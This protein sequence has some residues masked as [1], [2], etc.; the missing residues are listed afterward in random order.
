MK[1]TGLGRPAAGGAGGLWPPWAVRLRRRARLEV[2]PAGRP[3]ERPGA[4]QRAGAGAEWRRGRGGG[5]PGATSPPV[6]RSERPQDS[7]GAPLRGEA[8][9][10]RGPR[11]R[12]ARAA[13]S[14]R[15]AV[16]S[17]LGKEEKDYRRRR[18]W[19]AR[20]PPPPSSDGTGGTA[21]L[22][23]GFFPPELAGGSRRGRGGGRPHRLSRRDPRRRAAARQ[24]SSRR[25][26]SLPARVGPRA[27]RCWRR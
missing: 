9:G 4:A 13:A 27:V 7:A 1:G 25:P 23:W 12:R 5:R 22:L 11:D 6:P 18:V 16:G 8:A 19:A 3:L 21:F 20:E 26:A 17:E 24:H 15:A 10:A 14:S 2:A